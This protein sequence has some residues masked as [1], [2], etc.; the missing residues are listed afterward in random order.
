MKIKQIVVALAAAALALSVGACGGDPTQSGDDGGGDGGGQSITVGSANFPESEI[1]GQIYA[2]ALKAK[3]I[4]VDT[5]FAIG[6]REVY[7][8]ALQ[9]GEIDLIPEYT[10]NLL[11]YFDKKATA[12]APEEVTSALNEALP[13]DLT[14][15]TPAAAEDKDTLNVT[16]AFADQ[17]HLASIADLKGIKGLTL[18]ANPE[19]K[20]RS[21]GIPGLEAK[22]GITGVAFK[23]ISDGGGP[24]TVSN[25]VNGEVQVADIYSTSPSITTNDLVTLEDPE[26]L[27]AAQNVVPLLRNA[28]VTDEVTQVLDDVSAKLTTQDLLDLNARNQGD[29]KAEPQ[30][31][32]ADWLKD[33]G[34][35]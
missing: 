14:A 25:L 29:E 10:G 30:T 18:A 8:P 5:K 21:Y 26:H 28:A 7:V 15:L 35:S 19:F 22:Y 11:T 24:K 33:K 12:T 17:H 9:K 3:G 23:G 31:L 4:D 2:Q 32:A 20:T 6:A 1:I 27:I 34:L 13:D 16:R